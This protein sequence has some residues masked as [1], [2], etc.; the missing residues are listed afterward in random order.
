MCDP[1]TATITANQYNNHPSNVHSPHPSSLTSPP[2]THSL[3]MSRSAS[4][5]SPSFAFGNS[6]LRRVAPD[7]ATGGDGEEIEGGREGE[8][9]SKQGNDFALTTQ[10][11]EQ[12]HELRRNGNVCCLTTH[13]SHSLGHQLF[14]IAVVFAYAYRLQIRC[15]WLMDSDHRSMNYERERAPYTSTFFGAFSKWIVD[16]HTLQDYDVHVVR[17]LKPQYMDYAERIV[18]TFKITGEYR[19]R[20][21]ST[22]EHERER[23]RTRDLNDRDLSVS[24]STHVST[25]GGSGSWLRTWSGNVSRRAKSM[26]HMHTSTPPSTSTSPSSATSTPQQQALPASGSVST[27]QNVLNIC[28]LIGSFHNYRYIDPC[29]RAFF[30]FLKLDSMKHGALQKWEHAKR[31]LNEPVPDLSRVIGMHFRKTERMRTYGSIYKHLNEKYY[32]RALQALQPYIVEEILNAHDQAHLQHRLR[33]MPSSFT[34]LWN[35]V[36]DPEPKAFRTNLTVTQYVLCFCDDEERETTVSLLDE[37]H[38]QY[39]QDWGTEEDNE[40]M[41]FRHET[42]TVSLRVV[43][44]FLMVPNAPSMED[45]EHM[46]LLSQC[47]YMVISNSLFGWWSAYFNGVDGHQILYPLNWQNKLNPMQSCVKEL[48]ATGANGWSD[49]K[50]V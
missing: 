9:E 13:L 29:K 31:T 10:C 2:P 47:K 21:T 1:A 45:W 30:E 8:G 34:D 16:E 22:D 28:C 27:P 41:G 49:W 3:S 33:T 44:R 40:I 14:S 26:R 5:S 39:S 48:C 18:H 12:L 7:C 42:E 32:A 19:A 35:T 43:Y 23:E 46:L 37:M 17:E 36:T 20:K 15:K 24:T 6:Y 25:S 38:S 11:R 50:G 4:P